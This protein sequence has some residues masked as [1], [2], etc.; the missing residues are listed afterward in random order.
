VNPP[1]KYR[2]VVSRGGV[3]VLL[4]CL[5]LMFAR[6]AEAHNLTRSF[7]TWVLADYGATHQ[8]RAQVASLDLLRIGDVVATNEALAREVQSRY[9]TMAGDSPCTPG[10]PRVVAR[11][12]QWIHVAWQV[13]CEP[14]EALEGRIEAFFNEAPGHLVVAQAEY[15]DSA[16]FMAI[17]TRAQRAWPLTPPAESDEAEGVSISHVP[18]SAWLLSGMGHVVGGPDHVAFLLALLL[19]GGGFGVLLRIVTAFTIAHSITLG[20]TVLGWVNPQEAA[21]ETWV[22]L[23]ILLVAAEALWQ[24][25]PATRYPITVGLA[26]LHG[27]LLV[28]ALLGLAAIP[29]DLIAA[30]IVL[31]VFYVALAHRLPPREVRLRTSAAFLFGLVHGFAFA[32]ALLGDGPMPG[33]PWR[34]LLG[35]NLGVEAGQLLVVALAWP[36]LRYIKAEQSDLITGTVGALLFTGAL[37]FTFFQGLGLG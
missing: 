10:S 28:A 29:V 1:R 6:P 32:G 30:G 5:G 11:D 25:I 20:A 4:L 19:L 27:G 36:L 9:E 18:F 23:S 13:T 8:V 35:F 33:E 24:R 31:S 15:P 14:K 21:V 26:V 2:K 34:V 3:V 37:G 12:G 22:G 7:V 16:P 17:L